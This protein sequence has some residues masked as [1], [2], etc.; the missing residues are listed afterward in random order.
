MQNFQSKSQKLINILKFENLIN[1]DFAN[2][3]TKKLIVTHSIYKMEGLYF[4]CIP[5]LVTTYI[6]SIT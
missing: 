1:W 2:L 5:K 3:D 6:F 4:A